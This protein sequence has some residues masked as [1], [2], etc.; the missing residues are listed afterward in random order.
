MFAVPFAH[1]ADTHSRDGT[2][3]RDNTS[4]NFYTPWESMIKRYIIVTK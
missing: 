2:G 4:T 1:H 3:P